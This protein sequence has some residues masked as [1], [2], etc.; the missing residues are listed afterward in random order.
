MADQ[1]THVG[2]TKTGGRE[3]VLDACWVKLAVDAHTPRVP[4]VRFVPLSGALCVRA[5]MCV[6][7]CVCLLVA[8]SVRAFFGLT[9]CPV[10]RSQGNPRESE[11]PRSKVDDKCSVDPFLLRRKKSSCMCDRSSISRKLILPAV[12]FT[13]LVIY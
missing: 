8:L 12:E 1:D 11:F 7:V 5:C 13:M 4:D 9:T 10:L 3:I 6:Y 2:A